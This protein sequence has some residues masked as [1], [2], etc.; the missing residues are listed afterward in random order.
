MVNS[1]EVP[2]KAVMFDKPKLLLGLNQKGTWPGAGS[3]RFP[4]TDDAPPAERHD[5]KPRFE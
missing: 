2:L 4:A 3:Q 5:L 1:S